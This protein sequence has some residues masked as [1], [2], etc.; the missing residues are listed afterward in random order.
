MERPLSPAFK[1]IGDHFSGLD[2]AMIP[3]MRY[4]LFFFAFRHLM[5]FRCAPARVS[6]VIDPGCHAI[7]RWTSG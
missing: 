3:T 2:L 4:M 1:E 7:V 6:S 5:S